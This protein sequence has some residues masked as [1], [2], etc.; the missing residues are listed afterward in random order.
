MVEAG[1]WLPVLAMTAGRASPDP[2]STPLLLN[3]MLLALWMYQPYAGRV[4][5]L[6]GL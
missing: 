6:F 3:V 4:P 5:M 1:V 2:K